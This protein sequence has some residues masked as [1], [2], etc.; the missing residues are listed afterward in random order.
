[1]MEIL[2]SIVV[3]VARERERIDLPETRKKVEMGTFM[4]RNRFGSR[5]VWMGWVAL[6]GLRENS[7]FSKGLWGIWSYTPP[8]KLIRVRPHHLKIIG[9]VFEDDQHGRE[10]FFSSRHSSTGFLCCYEVTKGVSVLR[11]NHV[12]TKGSH[13]PA[14]DKALEMIKQKF[15]LLARLFQRNQLGVCSEASAATRPRA[16]S[17]ARDIEIERNLLTILYVTKSCEEA[18]TIAASIF[19]IGGEAEERR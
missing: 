10:I 3:S 18:Y 17:T 15:H 14:E 19:S 9:I 13:Y 5:L 16:A 8:P 11:K 1:M 6:V 4:F 7:G 12:P 2:G